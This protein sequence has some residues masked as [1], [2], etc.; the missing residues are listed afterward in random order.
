MR[1]PQIIQVVRL[2][3]VREGSGVGST[4]TTAEGMTTHHAYCKGD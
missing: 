1:I 4:P 2:I 3:E